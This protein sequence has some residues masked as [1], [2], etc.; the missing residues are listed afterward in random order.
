[1]SHDVVR[2]WVWLINVL[3][4]AASVCDLL[5]VQSAFRPA[6]HLW[7]ASSYSLKQSG[8]DWLICDYKHFFCCSSLTGHLGWGH[9]KVRQSF[10]AQCFVGSL[11]LR[12]AG[13][14]MEATHR[15][16]EDRWCWRKERRCWTPLR[17]E[18]RIRPAVERMKR[19]C[20]SENK[21]WMN[22]CKYSFYLIKVLL[23]EFMHVFLSLFVQIQTRIFK[24][25]N[26]VPNPVCQSRVVNHSFRS[27]LMKMSQG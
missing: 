1:M 6:D 7:L 16:T 23:V 26:C 27:D 12:L 3:P 10:A 20:V 17:A 9:L 18:E 14:V 22:E 4:E 2:K 21:L 24:S 15:P 25:F 13:L 5:D 11:C 8:I 19:L